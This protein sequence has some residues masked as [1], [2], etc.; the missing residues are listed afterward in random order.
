ME[1]NLLN[2]RMSRLKEWQD[3]HSISSA[4]DKV[5]SRTGIT[6]SLGAAIDITRNAMGR[7]AQM[8]AVHSSQNSET[9]WTAQMRHNALGQEIQRLLP[10]AVVSEWQYNATGKPKRHAVHNENRETRKRSYAWDINNQL[11]QMT[12]ELTGFRTTYGYDEFS[13]LVS[14]SYDGARSRL[15]SIFRSSDEVGNIYETLDMRD[16]EYGAGSNYFQAYQ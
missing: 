5:G 1:N 7:M 9:P 4:Y 14:A 8:T 16:R 3:G 15:S 13:N 6:S 12:N 2:E 10:G 11:K